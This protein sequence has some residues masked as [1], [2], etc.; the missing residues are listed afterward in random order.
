[1]DHQWNL[2]LLTIVIVC[3]VQTSFVHVTSERRAG[4]PAANY[5]EAGHLQ[6]A[7][8]LKLPDICITSADSTSRVAASGPHTV[9]LSWH[10]SVPASTK[11]TD[12]IA[13]YLVYRSFNSSVPRNEPIGVTRVPD[14]TY[15]DFHVQPGNYYY[16]VRAVSRT[17]AKSGFSKVLPV[18]VP[19]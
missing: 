11:K 10:A 17:G 12:A 6:P 16:V 15:S 8:D 3:F 19:R 7:E 2:R 14:T 9:K 13:C 4:T 5:T 18:A 1:M